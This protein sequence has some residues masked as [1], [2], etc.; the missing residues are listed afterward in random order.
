MQTS[1]LKKEG[2]HQ[3][4][5]GQD[6][7]CRILVESK[8][9]WELRTYRR[10]VE[11]LVWYQKVG[12]SRVEIV[13]RLYLLLMPRSLVITVR[14]RFIEGYHFKKL[15]GQDT[16]RTSSRIMTSSISMIVSCSL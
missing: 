13:E 1:C 15:K 4:S 12:S 5:E 8:T 14:D 11:K 3:G 10:R 16:G 2:R 6:K 7:G 9:W